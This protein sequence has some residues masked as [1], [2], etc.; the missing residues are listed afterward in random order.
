MP[1]TSVHSGSPKSKRHAQRRGT[2]LQ[3]R[4]RRKDLLIVECDSANLAADG[5]NLG[6][7]Y[8]WLLAH[9]LLSP[10][11]PKKTVTLVKTSTAHEL[12]EEFARA[13]EEHG[14]S[15]AILIVGHS[16]DAGLQLA[17]D[18]FCDW[19]TVGAWLRPFEPQFVVLA[20]CEAGKSG[21]VRQLFEPMKRTLQDVYASPVK[22]YAPQAAALAVLIGMRLWYKEI[23][24]KHSLALRVV[25]YIGTG[26][27][28]YRWKRN[29]TGQGQEVSPEFWDHLS[30]VF[31][32]G[33]WDLGQ[34]VTEFVQSRT[35][36]P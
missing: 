13:F 22:L 31:D 35:R 11:L 34:M 17:S 27:Q 19:R 28:L 9:P 36:K 33:Q 10:I 4:Q 26:G 7:A 5:L 18:L 3:V 2:T 25:N 1:P 30:A 16:N 21:A 8:D 6:T 14:R 23:G 24:D 32:R 29:E 20:A 15:R 12:R